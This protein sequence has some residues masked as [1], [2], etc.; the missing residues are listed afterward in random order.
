MKLSEIKEL[1][2]LNKISVIS[3]TEILNKIV[4][5]KR[6]DFLGIL[7]DDGSYIGYKD[8]EMNSSF[9]DVHDMIDS[10]KDTVTLHNH[11]FY[12]IIFCK[13]GN[14][15]YLIE[16]KRY[17]IQNGN[18][19]II[20]PGASHRPLLRETSKENYHRTVIW[21]NS[22]FY[23]QCSK[24]LK[25]TEKVEHDPMLNGHYV[26]QTSG[27]L[28]LQVEQIIELLLQEKTHP[29]PSS[30]F[31]CYSLFVQLYCLFYRAHCYKNVS[32]SK[33]EKTILL[34]E[35][36]HYISNNLSQKITIKSI[37]EHFHIS[38]SSVNQL[39]KKNFDTSVYKLITQK[40][41]TTSK[42]LIMENVPLKE[43]QHQCGFSDFSDSCIYA[44][45]NVLFSHS[46]KALLCISCY[47]L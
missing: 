1:M 12:E 13:S 43:I 15:Q 42:K 2:R 7:A 35:I 46:A 20:P 23:N 16:D 37:A 17:N 25:L 26:L 3:D 31:Y 19:I 34:D 11:G 41:L 6:T 29:N 27:T 40:R 32:Y 36:L 5:Q 44:T 14:I 9:I 22:N 18:I 8:I 10:E 39:F 33:P 30:E 21:I 45:Y 47:L 38:E 4:N 24:M 28:Y